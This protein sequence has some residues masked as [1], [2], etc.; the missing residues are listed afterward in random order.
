MTTLK[1]YS[2]RTLLDYTQE[3]LWEHLYGPFKLV[4]DDGHEITTNAREVQMSGYGWEYHREYRET[5]LLYQHHVQYVLKGGLLN[6]DTHLK[7]LSECMWSVY[8]AYVLPG[9]QARM[10]VANTETEQLEMREVDEVDLRELLFKRAYELTNY[11]YNDLSTRCE[12]YVVSLNILDFM[13]VLA[14]P[15][16]RE[17]NN[18]LQPNPTSINNAYKVIKDTLMNA[19]E[20]QKNPLSKAVHSRTVKVDQL[21]QCVGPRGTLTDVDSYVFRPPVL[22]GY[23]R[24]FRKLYE[25]LVESRSAAKSLA[26]SKAQ[27]QDA[28]YFSRRLQ[29]VDQ[30]VQNLHMGDCGSTEYVEWHVRGEE[31]EAGRVKRKADLKNLV[32]K[33][34][35][36]DRDGVLK[37]VREQDTH[38]IGQRLKFRTVLQCAHPDP[39]GICS[40]CFGGLSLSVPRGSNIGHMCCTHMTQKSSQSVL[41]LKHLDMS[42]DVDGVIIDSDMRKFVR[43]AEDESSYVLAPELKK[44]ESVKMI[45]SPTQARALSDIRNVEDVTTLA[46]THVS[47]METLTLELTYEGKTFTEVVPVRMANRNASMTHE[48][49]DYVKMYGWTVEIEKGNNVIDMAEWDWNQPILTLPPKHFNMSDHS[50]AIARMLESTVKEVDERDSHTDP[51]EFLKEFHD[52]VNDKL[53]VN[54][55][56][57]EV[58]VLGVT[59]RSAKNFDYRLPKPGTERGLGVRSNIMYYRSAAAL[60]AFQGHRDFLRNPTSYL[61]G[62]NK[63]RPNHLWTV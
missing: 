33:H 44:A 3:Q 20:L 42:S 45:V 26:S 8:D 49:L 16:V 55:A 50:A 2:A 41:S 28:E 47:E 1:R 58:I 4:F 46:L 23:A 25:A 31:K 52:L 37:V 34:Y 6:A 24:G 12:E 62:V 56:V 59:I 14:H 40:T 48:L 29:L 36:D 19:P 39:Y 17:V 10:L 53:D 35:W 38:L 27:L 30:V 7:M 57:N 60:F 9:Y 54:L 15:R 22:R 18:N 5:P 21:M 11:I 51:R 63:T 13:D 43:A 61:K 32:G